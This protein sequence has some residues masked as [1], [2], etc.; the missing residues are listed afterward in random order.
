MGPVPMGLGRRGALMG[1]MG[2]GPA[3]G[4]PGPWAQGPF[5]SKN[6]IISYNIYIMVVGYMWVIYYILYIIYLGNWDF[7]KLGFGKLGF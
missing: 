2:P 5:W 4:G 3:G 1:P 6:L 7:E